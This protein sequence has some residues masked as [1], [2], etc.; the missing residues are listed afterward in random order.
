MN[1]PINQYDSSIFKLY[2]EYRTQ[3]IAAFESKIMNEFTFA[4]D[5]I[6]D[7][8]PLNQFYSVIIG[9]HKCRRQ[10][11]STK[12]IVLSLPNVCKRS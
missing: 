10:A 3:L 1:Y 5:E 2:G 6:T 12:R 11:A 7:L 9:D 8:F 4:F